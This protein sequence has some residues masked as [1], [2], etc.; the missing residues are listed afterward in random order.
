MLA[1]N[2]ENKEKIIIFYVNCNSLNSSLKYGLSI[3][4]IVS[5][6]Q[7]VNT[8]NFGNVA[9]IVSLVRVNG[10]KGKRSA[11]SY[12]CFRPYL[13]VNKSFGQAQIIFQN[14]YEKD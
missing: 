6:V 1:L 4:D 9:S 12:S 11:L 7:N 2:L 8:I 3:I 14:V 10:K 5:Y 13:F